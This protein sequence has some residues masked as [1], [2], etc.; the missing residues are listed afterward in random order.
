MPEPMILPTITVMPL[1]RVIFGFRVISVSWVLASSMA[2]VIRQPSG[3]T[4]AVPSTERG[5]I[6]L[7]LGSQAR[8]TLS[9]HWMKTDQYPGPDGWAN[10]TWLRWSARPPLVFR[11]VDLN[12][13]RRNGRQMF[14]VL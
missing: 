6:T 14:G 12:R 7:A 3:R 2:N 10:L 13:E 4:R 11:L 1:T 9:R 5:R 8:R